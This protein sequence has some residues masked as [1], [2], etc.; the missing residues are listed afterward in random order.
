MIYLILG[1][2]IFFSAHAY[3]AFRTREPAGDIKT[4]WGE[5]PYMAAYS[6]VSLVGFGL[7]IY[8]YGQAPYGDFL[9]LPPEWSRSVIAIA[10]LP[11]LILIVSA[12]MPRGYI[13]S[14]ARHPMLLAVLIWSG[15]H[16]AVGVTSKELLLFGAF[17]LYALIDLVAVSRRPAAA[18]G[19]PPRIINDLLVVAVGTAAY[20]G[21]VLWG[22]AAL[23]GVSPM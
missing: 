20:F 11:A 13:K 6:L 1:L 15:T 7:A 5:G 8:G 14:I 12:Y 18:A 10:M 22:H 23:F 19:A 16:I 4:R 21:L 9:F 2:L 3:S 17:G